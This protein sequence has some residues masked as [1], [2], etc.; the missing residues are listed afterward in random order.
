MTR[1]AVNGSGP[2]AAM[3]RLPETAWPVWSAPNQSGREPHDGSSPCSAL[4]CIALL[5]AP[6][7]AASASPRRGPVGRRLLQGQDHPDDHR[8]LRRRRLRSARAAAGA[9]MSKHIPG[10]PEDRPAEHARRR[11][12]GRGE[13]ARQR[14]A[15]RTAPCCS[16]SRRT[17]RSARRSGSTASN[18]TSASSTTSATPPTARTSSIPGTRPASPRSS[19]SWRRSLWSAPPDAAAAPTTIRPR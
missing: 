1:H 18:T 2:C 14:R 10:N 5:A 15:A 11:R 12:A 7:V 6:I 17:F 19:R 16:R 9:H 13:L 8:R 4:P 3:A